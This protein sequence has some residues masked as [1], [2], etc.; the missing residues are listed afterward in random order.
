MEFDK[1]SEETLLN[2]TDYLDSL[3]EKL[4]CSPDY[5][6]SYAMGVLTAFIGPDLGT[7]VINKQTPNRQLWLSSP[8]SGP[9]R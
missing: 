1:I 3:P 6:I 4:K 7:Y 8:V 5:D 2:L 9:K